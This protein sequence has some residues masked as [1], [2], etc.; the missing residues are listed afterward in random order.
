MTHFNKSIYD[1]RHCDTSA[2]TQ[3]RIK[4]HLQKTHG[5]SKIDGHI[6]DKSDQFHEEILSVLKNCY[7]WSQTPTHIDGAIDPIIASTD[8]K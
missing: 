2:A 6:D 8:D 4:M 7:D 5:L 1:C 3:Q